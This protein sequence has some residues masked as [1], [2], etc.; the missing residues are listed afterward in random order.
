MKSSLV[1]GTLLRL[2]D[3]FS[4]NKQRFVP[5]CMFG[6]IEGQQS[7]IISKQRGVRTSNQT[8]VSV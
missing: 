3:S 6:A 4:R 2:H 5:L 8:H 1:R 7:E